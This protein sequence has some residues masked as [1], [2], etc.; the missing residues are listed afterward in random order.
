M[1]PHV[2]TH[3]LTFNKQPVNATE[4]NTEA[5]IPNVVFYVGILRQ[6]ESKKKEERESVQ[7]CL[8]FRSFPRKTHNCIK[9]IKLP[10]M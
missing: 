4:G 8:N 5:F 6:N 7:M 10:A 2:H 3:S 9:M 1:N